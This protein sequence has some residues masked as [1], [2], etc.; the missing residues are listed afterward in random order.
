MSEGEPKNGGSGCINISLLVRSK[1][2]NYTT[3]YPTKELE[4]Q[5]CQIINIAITLLRATYNN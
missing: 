3:F 4:D 5:F 1:H 2:Q